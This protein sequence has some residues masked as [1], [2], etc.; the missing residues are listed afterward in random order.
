MSGAAAWIFKNIHVNIYMIQEEK[1]REREKLHLWS[2]QYI[3]LLDLL[4]TFIFND[5]Y[6]L[7]N[8]VLIYIL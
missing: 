4:Q 6:I 3:S 5:R 7:Y 1:E 8:H 2:N